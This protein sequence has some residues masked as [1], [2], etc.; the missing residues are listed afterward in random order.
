MFSNEP[1]K[2][3]PTEQISENTENVDAFRWRYAEQRAFE[4]NETNKQ[5]KH[6]MLAAILVMVSSFAVCFLLL[7]GVL[8]WNG[9]GDT[10]SLESVADAVDRVNPSTVLVSATGIASQGYGTGFF[11]RADGYIVTNYHVIE[12]ATTVRVKLYSGETHQATVVGYSVFDDLAVLKIAGNH[13]PAVQIGDSSRVRVG[14]TVIAIGNPGGTEGAWTT[15]RGIVSALDRKIVINEHDETY[16]MTMLQTDAPVNTGNSG[17]P[18]CNARGEVIGIV[19]RKLT[20]YESLGFALPINGSMEIVHA[21]IT[22]G[23]ANDVDSSITRI[24]PTLGIQCYDVVKGEEYTLD[25]K[26]FIAAADG[27]WVA[28]VVEDSGADGVLEIGDIIVAIDGTTVSDTEAL[29]NALFEYRAGDQIELTVIREGREKK[30]SVT[31]KKS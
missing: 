20:G 5:R 13:Y 26:S 11:V 9:K 27:V 18:L 12:Q 4:K 29:K 14:E 17:G 28:G 24:R 23:H 16:E 7:C 8:I 22:H 25:G 6:G 19:T 30:L 2:E 3:Q 1:K 15:T 21:I 10:D 31:L